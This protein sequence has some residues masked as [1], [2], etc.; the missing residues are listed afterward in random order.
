MKQI[1]QNYR[2]GELKV[3][4][5]PVPSLKAGGLLIRN[6]NSLISVGTERSTVSISKKNVA[7]KQKT[8]LIR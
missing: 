6:I 1:I 5:V 2:S 4:E 7:V 3:N 8:D